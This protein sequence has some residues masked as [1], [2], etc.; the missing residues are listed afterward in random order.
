MTRTVVPQAPERTC[1][2]SQSWLTRYS[3]RPLEPVRP[4]WQATEQGLGQPPAV[5]ELDHR[6]VVGAPHREAA[7][8]PAVLDRVGGQ[9]LGGQL[10]SLALP[11]RQAAGAGEGAHREPGGPEVGGAVGAPQDALAGRGE[12]RTEVRRRGVPGE[13]GAGP[14]PPGRRDE[15]VRAQRAGADVPG[16]AHL[17][18]GAQQPPRRAVGEGGGHQQLVQPALGVLGV[19][20]AGP[21]RLPDAAQRPAVGGGLRQ[22][23]RAGAD[24]PRR[25]RAQC[26]DVQPADGVGVRAQGALQ[27]LQPP[28]GLGDHDVLSGGEALADVGQHA[29]EER[30]VVAVEQQL[31][32]EGGRGRGRR[33]ARAPPASTPAGDRAGPCACMHRRYA[34]ATA[35]DRVPAGASAAGVRGPAGC[36][37]PARGR[38]RTASGCSRGRTAGSARRRSRCSSTA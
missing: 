12:R 2:R 28:G 27:Q 13:G 20:A 22:Q 21:R 9:L 15:R 29:G 18:V 38:R 19:V 33:H 11:G 16:E 6:G 10:E 37:P 17:V 26:R 25:V 31:V 24:E 30:R 1:T 5:A 7:T 32:H 36:P 35:G 34:S 14:P 8:A 4:R 3:P 23:R